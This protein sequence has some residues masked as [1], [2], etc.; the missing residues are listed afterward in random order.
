MDT[1]PKGM[2]ALDAVTCLDHLAG[3]VVKVGTLAIVRDGAPDLYPMNYAL[4]SG[5]V[6][7]RTAGGTKLDTLLNGSRVAFAVTEVDPAWHDGWSVVVHGRARLV[8]D[9]NQAEKL[10]GNLR[11]WARGDKPWIFTIDADRVTGRQLF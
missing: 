5:A 6:T 9:P 8:A 11:P 7:F 1:A 10:A 3:H 2:R 4:Q